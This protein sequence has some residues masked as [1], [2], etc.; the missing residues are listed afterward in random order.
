MNHWSLI[1]IVAVAAYLINRPIM[2]FIKK[3]QG[4]DFGLGLKAPLGIVSVISSVLV[5]FLLFK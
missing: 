3:S 5:T 4:V 1:I 2:N